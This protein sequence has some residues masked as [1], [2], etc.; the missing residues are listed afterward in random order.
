MWPALVLTV[1]TLVASCAGQPDADL[2]RWAALPHSMGCAFPVDDQGV[3]PPGSARIRQVTLYH[4]GRDQLQLDVEYASRIP[5]E[6]RVANTAWGPIDAPGS[7]HTDF[8]IHPE[9]A[10]SDAVIS[11]TSPSPSVGQGWRADTSLFGESNPDVLTSVGTEGRVLSIVLDLSAHPDILGAGEFKADV[12]VVT[13][14]SGQPSVS[15]GPNVFPVRSPR[16]LWETA[17]AAISSPS[18]TAMPAPSV[19]PPPPIAESP[20]PGVGVT[21]YVRTQSGQVRCVVSTTSVACERTSADGFPQAPASA[22]GG[23]RWNLAGVDDKGAFTWNEG[24]IGGIDPNDDLVLKYAVTR[25]LSG[26][27]IDP[28]SEGTRFTNDATGHGMFVSIENVY[29]F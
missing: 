28:R 7:I 5:P 26:W 15:G 11:V 2:D 19:A 16:C 22:S 18:V 6:P 13:M 25:Q 1:G 3:D 17:P 20:P 29:A 4:A 9:H 14:V 27:S 10:P 12:D 21:R 23:G 24:N 8:L